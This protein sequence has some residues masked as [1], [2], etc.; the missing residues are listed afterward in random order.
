MIDRKEQK[1]KVAVRDSK[2]WWFGISITEETRKE[3]WETAAQPLNWY[4]WICRQL[5]VPIY[6]ELAIANQ[7]P[8]FAAMLWYQAVPLGLF[9]RL[10]SY[11]CKYLRKM[12]TLL[13][14]AR[15]PASCR[16][17]SNGNDI[18]AFCEGLCIALQPLSIIGSLADRLKQCRPASTSPLMRD[19]T[20]IWTVRAPS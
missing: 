5:N 7:N 19:W 13:S 15:L 20:G 12:G 4:D 18:I 1:L 14:P 6:I 2:R 9:T 11:L 17:K 10:R 8:V 16:W 3:R